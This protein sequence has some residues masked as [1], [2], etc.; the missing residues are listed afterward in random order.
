VKKEPP[1][2]ENNKQKRYGIWQEDTRRHGR[3]WRFN[4]RVRDADG[5]LCRKT[6]SGFATKSECETAVAALRLAA[7]EARYG[8]TRPK[9][10][11]AI[12]VGAVVDAYIKA[13]TSKW[14]AKHGAEYAA[15]NT[16]QFN[17]L[18]RWADFV[19]NEKAV[20]DLTKQDFALWAQHELGR[21]LAASSVQRRLNNIRAALNDAIETHKELHGHTLPRYSMGREASRE[22]MRILDDSEIRALSQFFQSRK[23][24]RD[25]FDFFRVALGTG[26]RFDEIAPVVVRRDMTTAG[27]KWTDINKNRGTIRLFSGKTG[28]ERIIYVPAVVDIL[29]ERKKDKLGDDV[30]AFTCRDHSIRK[31]FAKASRHCGIAYG[32]R[33]PGGWTV[34]DL[35]H[36]CL[37]HLLQCGVDLATVRD[38]AG[39]STIAETSKYVHATEKSKTNLAQASSVL[40]ALAAPTP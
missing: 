36:T 23:E 39:H 32:Q 40:M 9:R 13:L 14:T 6:G 34:H 10:E 28:K 21:G 38:F 27:I 7:R 24:Y 11:L 20:K 4:I 37:T 29:L 1:K 19:G 5:K 18:R 15:R 30:H 22:R 31:V 25:A 2:E 8:L 26:G 12:T 3:C 16:G 33:I 17:A 35:R